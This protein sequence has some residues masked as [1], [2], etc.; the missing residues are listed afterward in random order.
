VRERERKKRHEKANSIGTAYPFR[1]PW[2]RAFMSYSPLGDS[3]P[4]PAAEGFSYWRTGPFQ[5]NP[6][7]PSP[8]FTP[9]R[10]TSPPSLWHSIVRSDVTSRYVR[11]PSQLAA[12]TGGLRTLALLHERFFCLFLFLFVSAMTLLIAPTRCF[13][14]IIN[15]AFA[16]SPSRV[17]ISQKSTLN[18][19]LDKRQ[20]SERS[21]CRRGAPWEFLFTDRFKIPSFLISSIFVSW[22]FILWWFYFW[23]RKRGIR[24]IRRS[25][26]R[27]RLVIS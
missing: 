9:T 2:P 26:S 1:I 16:M 13:F 21:V 19:A 24:G 4:Y 11:A 7:N 6:V 18:G 8:T 12:A 5:P 17:G 23:Q 22:Y 14:I 3:L 25:M 15:P 27:Q 20:E 10:I